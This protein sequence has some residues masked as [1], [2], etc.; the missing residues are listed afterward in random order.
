MS[1]WP[2]PELGDVVLSAIRYALPRQTG[3]IKDH[4]A[5]TIEHWADIT[6]Y[7][8]E[9]ILRDCKRALEHVVYN[10]GFREVDPLCVDDVQRFVEWM[11]KQG[12]G[13]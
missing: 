13:E 3:I 6:S 4:I 7:F 5:F 8:R 1:N 2:D 10:T 9:L 11:T 12:S